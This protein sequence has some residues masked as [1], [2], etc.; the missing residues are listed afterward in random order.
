MGG[1]VDGHSGD[2]VLLAPPFITSKA[3]LATVVERL[4]AAVD[5]AIAA[6]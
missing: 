2:H 4:I 3:E 6:H 1:T 5:C